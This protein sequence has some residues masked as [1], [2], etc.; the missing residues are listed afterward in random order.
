MKKGPANLVEKLILRMSKE[1]KENPQ[2]GW[3]GFCFALECV[4]IVYT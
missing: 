3:L 4:S 1:K 2:A